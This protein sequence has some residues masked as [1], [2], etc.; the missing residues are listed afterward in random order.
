MEVEFEDERLERLACDVSFDMGLDRAVIKAFRMRVQYMVASPDERAFAS[1]NGWRFE[2]LKGDLAG[3][4]SIRLN[5]QWRLIV[6]L[7]KR[8]N[9]KVV[10][11]VSICDYH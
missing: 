4:Y 5:R 11:V 2:K 8:E 1:L 7:E 9:G 10:V 3:K 6:K